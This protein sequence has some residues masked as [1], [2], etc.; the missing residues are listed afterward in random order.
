MQQDINDVNEAIQ[1]STSSLIDYKNA[2][3]EIQWDIFD[4]IQDRISDINK[5]SDFLIDLM[6]NDKLFDDKGNI[7]DLIPFLQTLKEALIR[8]HCLM[9]NYLSLQIRHMKTG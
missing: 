7:T 8:S 3:Q 9:V 5:E 4:K 1:D 6:S 2:I